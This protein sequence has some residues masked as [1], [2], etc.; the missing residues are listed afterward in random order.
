MDNKKK[1]SEGESR[2]LILVVNDDGIQS[3]GIAA[4]ARAAGRFGQVLITA[5]V[6][7]QTSMGRA[8]PRYPDL[9]IIE[10]LPFVLGDETIMAY[11]V[12]SSPAHATAYGIL[13]IADRTPDL[14]VSGINLGA[15]LGRSITCSGTL[16]A[17]FEAASH[18][19]PCLAMSLETPAEL[20]M[21]KDLGEDDLDFQ[22]A[23]EVTAFWIAHILAQGIPRKGEI[24][25]VN[26]PYGAIAPEEYRL[27]C[28]DNQNYYELR[29]PP[30]R[31]WSRPY[32]MDFEIRFSE[33]GLAQNG[34]IRTLC[35]DRII[36]ATPLGWDLTKND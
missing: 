30:Q 4:A 27:T 15:N 24:L 19:I 7:Q 28:L 36:S 2:P 20:I 8:Y 10:E 33:E 25:N 16:G 21:R 18:G 5:P 13:E 35:M 32:T 31:D 1:L 29:R 3:P 26:V 12:H 6:T 11:G 34:D 17:C 9:G 22:A 23:E 14:V